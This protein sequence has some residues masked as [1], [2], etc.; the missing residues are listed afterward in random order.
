[1]KKY[2]M[3]VWNNDELLKEFNIGD[4][5]N[6]STQLDAFQ[7]AQSYKEKHPEVTCIDLC[8]NGDSIIQLA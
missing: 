2:T 3:K 6:G 8:K 7:R 4:R 1:M 5:L